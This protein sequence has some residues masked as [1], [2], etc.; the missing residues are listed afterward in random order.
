MN[1]VNRGCWRIEV[2][3]EQRLFVNRGQGSRLEHKFGDAQ[4]RRRE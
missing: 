2:V 1:L 3:C 4:A